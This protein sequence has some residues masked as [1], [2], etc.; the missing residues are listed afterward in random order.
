VAICNVGVFTSGTN[1]SKNGQ[2]LNS[3]GSR[4]A[5]RQNRKRSRGIAANSPRGFR[6]IRDEGPDFDWLFRPLGNVHGL[7]MRSR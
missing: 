4:V 1:E 2:L 5:A 7:G 3:Q 6:R